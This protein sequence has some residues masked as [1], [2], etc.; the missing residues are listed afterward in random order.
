MNAENAGST[1]ESAQESGGTVAAQHAENEQKPGTRPELSNEEARSLAYFPIENPN[2]ALRLS[3]D[4]RILFANPASAGLLQHMGWSVGHIAPQAWCEVAAA[5]LANDQPYTI[6][7]EF[8][9]RVFAFNVIPVMGKDYVNLY[10]TDVTHWKRAEEARR[11][12]EERYR[13]LFENSPDGIL[14]TLPDGTVL[15]ANAAACHMFGCSEDDIS[16]MSRNGMVDI[17]DPR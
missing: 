5:A 17:T 15:A 7:A 3:A 11:E 2:P 1:L 12:S 9:A 4:G 6:E 16:W 13:L 10:G 8:G 14:L